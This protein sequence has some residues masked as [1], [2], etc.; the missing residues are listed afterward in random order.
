MRSSSGSEF[1]YTIENVNGVLSPVEMEEITAAED[2]EDSILAEQSRY[3]I[4]MFYLACCVSHCNVSPPFP[5][6]PP[7]YL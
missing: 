6:L 1:E 5:S 7:F 2:R 4:T 3:V